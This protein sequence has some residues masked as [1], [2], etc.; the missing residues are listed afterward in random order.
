MRIALI[1]D[2]NKKELMIQLCIAYAGILHRHSLFATAQTGQYIKDAT[3]LELSTVLSGSGGGID[4]IASRVAMGEIDMLVYL[5]NFEHTS[6]EKEALIH[7]CDQA[8][9]PVATNA[10]TAEILIRSLEGG[11]LWPTEA[12]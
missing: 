9:V 6:P 4:Q 8:T 12:N 5:R 7:I 3:G 2:D 1:A 11:D 10:A